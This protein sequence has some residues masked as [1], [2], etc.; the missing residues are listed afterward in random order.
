MVESFNEPRIKYIYQDNAERSA[1]RNRGIK[2]AKGQFITFIDSDDQYEARHLNTIHDEIG[3]NDFKDFIYVVKSTAIK[4]TEKTTTQLE[5][6]IGQNDVETVLLNAITPG[7]ITVPQTIMKNQLFNEKIRISEDTELL[8]RLVKL[9]NLK[10]LNSY[11]FQYFLHD[12]N[13]V[14]VQKYNAFLQR[15]ETL[16]LIFSYHECENLSQ[17][18]K[19]TL[20][21]NCYFGIYKFYLHKKEIFKA[22]TVLLKAIIKY[23]RLRI[24]EKIY[25]FLN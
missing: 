13:S 17:S 19:N 15:K 6:K 12:D 18:F 7:Q 8:V 9:A 5:I 14:N 4:T 16:E 1:A 24:K 25:L 11:S 21:N 3:K 22:K 23:P 20:L 10:I 2:L